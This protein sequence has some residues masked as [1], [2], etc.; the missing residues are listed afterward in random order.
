MFKSQIKKYMPAYLWKNLSDVKMR[1]H[2]FHTTITLKLLG[3]NVKVFN[4]L[5]KK[6]YKEI[7]W[8]DNLTSEFVFAKSEIVKIYEPQYHQVQKVINV[9]KPEICLY[10]FENAK[11]HIESSHVILKNLIVMERLPHVLLGYCN[12]STGF[13]NGHNEF[14][15]LQKQSYDSIKIEKAFFLGG[16]GSW[17][18]YHWT[19]EIIPKLKYFLSS[20]L[21]TENIKIIIP[22]HVKNIKS[23]SVMLE[24][25]LGNRFQFIYL[26]KNQIAEVSQL[27][28]IT[29]PSNIVIN[30]KKNISFG[31]DFL[32]F[33]KESIEFLRKSILLS[34]QY[35]RF[36]GEFQNKFKSRKI[37]LAR[38]ESLV[39]KYNQDEVISLVAEFGFESIFLEDLSFFEQIYL[40]QNI[41]FLIGASGAAWTNLIYAKKGIRAISWLGENVGSFSSYSTLAQ[42]FECDLKFLE[43]QVLKKENTHSDYIVN[44]VTLE[45]LVNKLMS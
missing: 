13:I 27:Y 45:S 17:N 23:F 15:A 39:R 9:K 10:R 38:K 8:L 7:V 6:R 1:L 30:C 31:A 19:I 35:K 25:L 42:Y 33:D 16:N 26:T 32:Y 5:V 24:V 29:T 41:D 11:V 37:F 21:S 20:N 22:A 2:T 18:Y 34:I 40:F 14:F 12:Y 36:S 28:T 4:F 43:C 44:L 3:A